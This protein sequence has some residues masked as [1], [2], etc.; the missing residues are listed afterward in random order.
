MYV[1]AS[2]CWRERRVG[3]WANGKCGGSRLRRRIKSL[4]SRRRRRMLLLSRLRMGA[5]STGVRRRRWGGIFE[6]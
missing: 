2:L 1:F 6:G 4:A 5:G 3:E